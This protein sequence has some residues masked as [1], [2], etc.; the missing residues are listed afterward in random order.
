M[1]LGAVGL[2]R[3]SEMPRRGQRCGDSSQGPR[4]STAALLVARPLVEGC[5]FGSDLIWSARSFSHSP[6]LQHIRPVAGC[7]HRNFRGQL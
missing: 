6:C 7:Q 1:A 4:R 5:Y 2:P 3:E